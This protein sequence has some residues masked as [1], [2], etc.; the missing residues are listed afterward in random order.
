MEAGDFVEYSYKL[1]QLQVKVSSAYYLNPVE[2]LNIILDIWESLKN[3]FELAAG[4][5][6]AKL[7]YTSS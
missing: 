1:R 5:Y 3:R 6:L 2:V 4:L 7:L